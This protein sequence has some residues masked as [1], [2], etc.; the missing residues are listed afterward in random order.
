MSSVLCW[1]LASPIAFSPVAPLGPVRSVYPSGGIAFDW[2]V[3]GFGMCGALCPADGDRRRLGLC[4]RASPRRAAP[5]SSGRFWSGVV[6]AA[7]RAGLPAP[8][9][10]GV[11]MALE[12]GEGRSAVPVRSALL[13]SILAVALVVTT[14]TFGSSLQTLVSSPALY[15]WNWTYILQSGRSGGGNV[16]HVAFTL[17]RHD[18]YVAAYSGASYNDVEIDGQEVPFLMENASAAVAPPILSGQGV[19]VPHASRPG[20]G[21]ARTASQ[22]SRPLC[23]GDLRHPGRCARFT[24][25]QLGCG[26]LAPPPSLPLASRAPCPTTRPW[27]PACFLSNQDLPKAIRRGSSTADP[28]L[29]STVRTWRSCDSGLTRRRLRRW[30]ASSASRQRRTKVFAAAAGGS[31][32]Q[33]DRRAG[34]AAAG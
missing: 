27:A 26:S 34:R 21:H 24:C 13:G 14:V 17:L 9:I 32:W 15:G 12:P 7:A 3:L 18:P 16:P 8:V 20:R 29:L 33:R 30:P 23:H 2:T 22:A 5:A 25:R 19:T 6:A 31:G 28:F 11:R 4:V 10:V 1:P